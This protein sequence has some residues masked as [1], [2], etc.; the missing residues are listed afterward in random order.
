VRERDKGSRVARD[1]GVV[2]WGRQCGVYRESQSLRTPSRHKWWLPT[3]PL[4][5]SCCRT[6]RTSSTLQIPTL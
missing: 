5:Y 3:E 2:A 1:T 6:A 4:V